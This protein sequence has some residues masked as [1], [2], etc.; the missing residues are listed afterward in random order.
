MGIGMVV[1]VAASQVDEVIGKINEQ[2]EAVYRI[3]EVVP[4][5]NKAVLFDEEEK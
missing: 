2:G 5:K 4:L 3:G 1:A